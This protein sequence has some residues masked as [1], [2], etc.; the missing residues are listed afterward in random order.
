MEPQLVK[1]FR[2]S[3]G[4]VVEKVKPKVLSTADFSDAYWNEVQRGMAT[5][6]SAFGGFPYDFARKTGTSTQN[7]GGKL[8]DNGVFIAFAPRNNPKLAVAVMIPEGGFGSNSAAPVARAIFDAYDQEFGL[9]G[10]PKK[11][12]DKETET[13]TQ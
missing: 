10:V 11:N 2:D 3:E 8:V 12:K 6:V 1:E 7:I 5:E 9:D 13:S 4:N